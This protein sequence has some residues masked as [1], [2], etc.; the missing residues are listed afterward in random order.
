[1]DLLLALALLLKRPV[2]GVACLVAMVFTL[3]T[4]NSIC[5]VFADR[6]LLRNKTAGFLKS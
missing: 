3:S 6:I 1:M 2:D 5:A 4:T